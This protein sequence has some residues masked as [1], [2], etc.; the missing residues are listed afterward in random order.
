M[1]RPCEPEE[2]LMPAE[3]YVAHPKNRNNVLLFITGF[4][5]VA[6]GFV[7]VKYYKKNYY[8]E[9]VVGGTLLAVDL[10]LCLRADNYLVEMIFATEDSD[11]KWHVMET[12]K[13]LCELYGEPRLTEI[14]EVDSC[15]GNVS[16]MNF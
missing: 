10:A 15:L 14:V 4:T 11:N 12:I 6:K 5:G 3:L 2:Y 13:K 16:K 1:I 9:M 7:V 8:P